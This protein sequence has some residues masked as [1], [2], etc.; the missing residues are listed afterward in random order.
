MV[1]KSYRKFTVLD[2][3]LLIAAVAIGLAWTKYYNDCKNEYDSTYIEG[4]RPPYVR[5]IEAV[6]SCTIGLSHCVAV[7]TIVLLLLRF[8]GPRV[9]F[10]RL[11]CQPGVVAGGA[12]LLAVLVGMIDPAVYRI[13]TNFTDFNYA[14][15]CNLSD[16]FTLSSGNAS[17]AVASAWI[18]L[19]ASGRWRGGNDWIDRFG[20]ALGLFWLVIGPF[21]WLVWNV[22]LSLLP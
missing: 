3:L 13:R 1:L 14:N 21:T 20:L 15:V 4:E 16:Y 17:L 7:V 12:V 5:G 10:R 22:I 19:G 8:F 9:R 2:A 18:L 6:L 11:V